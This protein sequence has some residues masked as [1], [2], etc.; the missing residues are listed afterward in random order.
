MADITTMDA[1]HQ[2]LLNLA[3][4]Y[5]EIGLQHYDIKV[6]EE[7][8]DGIL[9]SIV[10]L[11]STTDVVSTKTDNDDGANNNKDS[12]KRQKLKS[13]MDITDL[14][15]VLEVFLASKDDEMRSR[16]TML[17]AKI[18]KKH[19]YTGIANSELKMEM[20]DERNPKVKTLISSHVGHLLVVFF[21]QRLSDYPSILPSL[22]ALSA[23]VNH[24]YASFQQQ[25]EKEYQYDLADILQY[26]FSNVHIPQL[27]QNIRYKSFQL[28][29][30]IITICQDL[31]QPQMLLKDVAL[32][33]LTGIVSAM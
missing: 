18:L 9:K 22:H 29:D 33:I 5:I 12:S 14:I 16:S 24:F 6:E 13:A 15:E 4:E 30:Q 8:E 19:T 32:D 7:N 10:S 26:L 2:E 28:I 17:L 27:A 11:I 31:P 3:T 25:S 23:L 20:E 21:R 1:P